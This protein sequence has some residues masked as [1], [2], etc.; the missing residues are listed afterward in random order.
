[1]EM[2][3]SCK[4]V[5]QKYSQAQEKKKVSTKSVKKANKRKLK[6]EEI[7]SANRKKL[8]LDKAI[9]ELQADIDESSVL[10]LAKEDYESM[11]LCLEK[12]QNNKLL[13][14]VKLKQSAAFDEELKKLE[15]EVRKLW[16]IGV[17]G[18]CALSWHDIFIEY[19]W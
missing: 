13:L 19:L 17:N 4:T 7:I 16:V 11:K 18:K 15:E 2:I 8:D 9:E 14:Q 6:E 10:A 3:L 5:Y 1:M 12:G